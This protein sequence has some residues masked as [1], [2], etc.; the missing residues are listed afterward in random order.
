MSVMG[1]RR[2]PRLAAAVLC[3]LFAASCDKAPDEPPP[4]R[5]VLSLVV[6]PVS[7]QHFGPFAGTVQPRYK[8]DL[9]FRASGRMIARNANVGDRVDKDAILASLDPRIAALAAA[10]S[11]ADLANAQAQLVNASG[12]EQRQT[13][14]LQSGSTAQAQ[15]DTAVAGKDTAQ[16]KV[17]QAEA[18]L[19]KAQ[20][21]LDYMTLR[22]DFEGVI[23]NWNAE[24]GQLVTAGQT[25]V[26]VARPDQRDAVFDVPDD[27]IGKVKPEASFSVSLQADLGVTTQGTVREI[28]P[29]ADAATRTR[30]IK[31]T[32]MSAPDVFRLGTTVAI[33]L[34]AATPP[35]ITIP[36]SAILDKDGKASVWLASQD[37][38]ATPKEVSLGAREGDSVTVTNGLTKGDRVIVAGVHSLSAGQPIKLL[39]R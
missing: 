7:E 13:T 23:T 14:L 5:P 18:A 25:V 6:E 21:Q 22:S 26:T 1:V 38:K 17:T 2:G 8:T 16:A 31:L 32:L 19:T 35:T 11:R 3:A 10:S 12:T 24:V 27:L 28:A 33:T 29:E 4:V 15:V 30:R 20:E 34:E 9:G 39:G 37:G 36:A